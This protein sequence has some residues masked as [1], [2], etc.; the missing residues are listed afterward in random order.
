MVYSDTVRKLSFLCPPPL[1]QPFTHTQY[2]F[3][4]LSHSPYTPPPP[5]PILTQII[6]KDPI[7]FKNADFDDSKGAMILS[8]KKST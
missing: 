4:Y 7:H 3:I 2:T 6:I 1:P 8:F 5:V